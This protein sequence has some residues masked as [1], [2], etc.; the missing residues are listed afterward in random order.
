M[1]EHTI[2]VMVVKEILPS[3]S[4]SFANHLC[5]NDSCFHCVSPSVRQRRGD[6]MVSLCQ[7]VL[8]PTAVCLRSTYKSSSLDATLAKLQGNNIANMPGSEVD[9]VFPRQVKCPAL[10]QDR[11]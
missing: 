3:R 5:S 6:A 9:E 2:T 10:Q 1:E 8:P 11:D 4:C 7:R